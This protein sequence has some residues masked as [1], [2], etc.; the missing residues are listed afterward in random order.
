[1]QYTALWKLDRHQVQYS[2]ISICVQ[3]V[4]GPASI[5]GGSDSAHNQEI[6][7]RPLVWEHPMQEGW[8]QPTQE[9]WVWE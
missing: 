1:M 8:E 5:H 6:V 2:T 7:S 3:L 9:G 4:A